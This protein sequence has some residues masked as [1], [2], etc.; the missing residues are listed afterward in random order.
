MIIGANFSKDQSR[1]LNSYNSMERIIKV[2]LPNESLNL[3][4]DKYIYIYESFPYR[5]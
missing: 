4:R 2:T 5:F 3:F 1:I